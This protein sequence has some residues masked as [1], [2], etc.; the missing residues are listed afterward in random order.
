MWKPFEFLYFGACEDLG[1]P[2]RLQRLIDE[3]PNMRV[4]LTEPELVVDAHKVVQWQDWGGQPTDR[5]PRRKRGTMMG[6]RQS[7]G[8]YSS[9]EAH[10]PEFESFGR[11]EVSD[12]WSCDIQDVTGLSSSKSNLEK[13]TSLDSMVETNSREMIDEITEDKLHKNLAHGEIRI[14]HRESTS[15]HFARYR[16]DGRTLL[17]NSGGSHHFAAARYIASRI[18][19]R[20]PLH[21]RLHT[22]S[23]S[24]L[25]LGALLRDFDMYAISDDATISN[26]FHHAMKM[27]RAT[28][29]W[30]HLPRPYEHARAIL[31]P[32]NERRSMR[33]SRA[34]REAGMFDIGEHLVAL[35][36]RQAACA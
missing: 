31:L 8:R 13:F 32:K 10:R 22:Y 18:N 1:R 11:C 17:M 20:V 4:Q 12:Q 21:G 36:D 29:L 25:A 9:F 2:M 19:R 5:W 24:P 16:W 35:T 27:F 3:N 28:Y 33:V 34:L 30:R 23:I 7:A 6:W 14:L 26:G 15:D